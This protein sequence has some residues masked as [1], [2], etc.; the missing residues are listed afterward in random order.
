VEYF[1]THHPG[2]QMRAL[3]IQPRGISKYC[4]GVAMLY[5]TVKKNA[6]KPKM[7]WIERLQGAQK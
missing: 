7:L 5:D 4:L 1:H 6:I 2:E 3:R